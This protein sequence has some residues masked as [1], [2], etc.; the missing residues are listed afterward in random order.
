MVRQNKQIALGTAK[1]KMLEHAVRAQANF[2]EYTPFFIIL[3]ALLELHDIANWLL[4][5]TGSMFL[6]GRISH[7]Y[8]LGFLEVKSFKK[9]LKFRV[10]G[11]AI[12]YSL[13]SIMS[14]VLIIKSL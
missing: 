10:L 11:T 3:F 12:T 13:L 5:I 6:F 14:L 7:A 9:G 1:D 2:V 8:S 4:I